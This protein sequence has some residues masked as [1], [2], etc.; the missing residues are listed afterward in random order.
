MKKNVKKIKEIF[1]FLLEGKHVIEASAG[2][3]K[4]FF[5][6]LTYIRLILGINIKKEK[7]P[8]SVKKILVLTFN[9][10]AKEEIFKRIKKTIQE[11]KLAILKKKINNNNIIVF[12]NKI[13]NFEL[14]KALLL[15]AEFDLDQAKI[16]TIDSF[17]FKTLNYYTFHLSSQNNIKNE[18]N[19]YLE[20][21]IDFWR[22]QCFL[23]PK[24]LLN[25]IYKK[26]KN[27]LNLFKEIEPW[28]NYQ[29]NN[30]YLKIKKKYC[31]INLHKK[32]IKKINFFKKSW[33]GVSKKI[34]NSI[35]EFIINKR[36]FN[37]RNKKRWINIIN[38][39]AIEKTVD[40]FIPKELSYFKKK[41]NKTKNKKNKTLYNFFIFTEFFLKEN[42]SIK[43]EF[44]LLSIK[45]VIHYTNLRKKNIGYLEYSD[46]SNLL[47]KELKK[48]KNNFLRKISK[49]FSAVLIDEFQD[50]NFQQHKII[51]KIFYER[52]NIFLL[53]IG[54]P[55]QSIYNFRGANI[56][57]Y[58]QSKSEIKSHFFLEKNWRS[59]PSIINNINLL[60]SRIKN[61]FLN[62]KIKFIPSTFF[63]KNKYNY[64]KINNII[65]PSFSIFINSNEI[66]SKRNYEE[67][68]SKECAKSISYW[69]ER[70]RSG[71]ATI[72][73]KN[74]IK[75]ISEKDIV[76]IV[77]NKIEAICIQDA[78]K[79]NNV[80]S[81]YL[82]NKKNIFDTLEAKEL[83]W[84]LTAILDSKNEKKLKRALCTNLL[85]NDSNQ[86]NKIFLNLEYWSSTINKF[87][88]FY[89]IWEKLG[90]FS[91][92]KHLIKIKKKKINLNEKKENIFNVNNFLHLGKIIDEKYFLLNEKK[93]L[94]YWLEGKI[95]NIDYLP[96]NNFVQNPDSNNS[97]KIISIHKSKGLEFPLVWIPFI[98]N[99]KKRKIGLYP[100]K[101]NQFRIN[102][103]ENS[104]KSKLVDKERLSEDM[105]LL[106]V[107]LTRTI[108]HCSLGIARVQTI[109][110]KK[111][112][113]FSNV[114]HSAF[115]YLLQRGKKCNLSIFK[116]NLKEIQ[117][118]ED[119]KFFSNFKEKIF[120]KKIN[121]NIPINVKKFNRKILNY[122]D[123]TSFS[124][125]QKENLVLTNKKKKNSNAKI[126][127]VS[128]DTLSP[129][130]FPR[131]VEFG[132][133]L[134]NILKKCKFNDKINDY[135]I[136]KEISKVKLNKE[137]IPII[138]NWM[139]QIFQKKINNYGLKLSNLKENEYLKELKFFYPI[140]KIIND[141][142]FNKI[143]KL[144]RLKNQ[145]IPL[146]NFEKKKGMLTG[147]IDLIF[148]SNKKY[149][150]LEYKSNWL[151]YD[152]SFYSKKNIKSEIIKHRYDIQS[153]LYIIALNRYLKNKIKKYNF[154]QNFGGFYFLFIRGM[155]LEKNKTNENN[156]IYHFLPKENC[157]NKLDNFFK[158]K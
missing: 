5:I 106:Y 148:F 151:G 48:K 153:L 19:M 111:Y 37:K 73:I 57:S 103:E 65:Q 124:K 60:F 61:P 132:S 137:W 10:S 8:L 158:G 52:K 139:Y 113:I 135:H 81:I 62:S 23:L 45:N 1:N 94:V 119:I 96:K 133:L 3:G 18:R 47:F 100:N 82:S 4:T 157:I 141:Y 43:K 74:K 59:T 39:W 64:F 93:I 76:V 87:Y 154:N 92:I 143:I 29:K 50:I 12:I 28:I 20:T 121:V 33:L 131:G 104:K 142:K 112:N 146:F 14:A 108:I 53:L 88:H 107:A 38:K 122:W 86:I 123:I 138:K 116:K 77:K 24:N 125:L 152:N 17:F 69:L 44:I 80:P 117:K 2:T 42:F 15:K 51:K 114:H 13:K 21:T 46:V 26:W 90:I 54:D 56:F 140:K 118:Y 120:Q 30:P 78:L 102:L 22:K 27:P 127:N 85:E 75:S 83:F 130:Y 41:I 9:K 34:F 79:K 58:F 55:K 66:I 35:D 98:M 16:F 134:H 109:R 31:V 6:V 67:W 70:G 97:V 155:Y 136:L 11:L 36:I 128:N 105:R 149:Y 84:I 129:Y 156:G 95:N 7:N 49:D 40:Y 126:I 89:K 25:I 32:N 63:K 144:F 68:I 101:K 71:N 91:L 99:Y 147:F 72:S 150:I 115:G 145:E 110:K